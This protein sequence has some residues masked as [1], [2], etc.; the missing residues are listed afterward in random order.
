MGLTFKQEINN[1]NGK[2]LICLK[3]EKELELKEIQLEILNRIE[4]N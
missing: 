2:D 4:E 3:A 1:L